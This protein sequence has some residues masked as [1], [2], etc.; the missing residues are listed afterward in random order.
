MSRVIV[1]LTTIPSRLSNEIEEGIKLCINSL[2]NQDYDNYEIHF[3]IPYKNNFLNQEYVIPEWLTEKRVQIYRTEDLGPVT[4]LVPTLERSNNPEDIII[5]VDDDLVY[6]KDM[7]KEQVSNQKKWLEESVGYDGLRSRDEEGNFSKHFGDVRDYYYTSNYRNSRVDI[8]QHYKSVSYKRR[9]FS[10]DFFEF[11]KKYHSWADDILLAAYMSYKKIDRIAT[12][13]PNDPQF[14][15]HQ[16]WIDKGGVLTFPILRNIHH[17][18]MEG[19]NVYRT[20]K[21]DD[22]GGELYKFIDNGYRK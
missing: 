4:K 6:H 2:V 1:T 8:L 10:D 7:I 5:V 18:R 13:H 11:V 17:E 9:Y 14:T 21:I 19:C 12:Y 22:N 3:N 15:S 16:E 20:E